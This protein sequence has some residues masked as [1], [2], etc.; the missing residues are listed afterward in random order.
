MLITLK[1]PCKHLLTPV[2]F[3]IAPIL[4]GMSAWGVENTPILTLPQIFPRGLY[5][6]SPQNVSRHLSHLLTMLA[7]GGVGF[8]YLPKFPQ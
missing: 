2:R 1:V 5:S 4:L 6:V 8:P 7:F 3:H